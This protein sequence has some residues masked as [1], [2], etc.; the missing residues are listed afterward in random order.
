MLSRFDDPRANRAYPS[1]GV[2]EGSSRP[3]EGIQGDPL[4]RRRLIAQIIGSSFKVWWM[5]P[6]KNRQTQ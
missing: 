2:C 5:A 4:V 1:L 6:R 3:H